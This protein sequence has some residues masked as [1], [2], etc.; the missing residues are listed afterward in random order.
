MYMHQLSCLFMFEAYF[1]KNTTPPPFPVKPVQF[2]VP[3]PLVLRKGFCP[4]GKRKRDCKKC[5]NRHCPCG[6]RRDACVK[7]H[8]SG[9]C[10]HEKRRRQC[11]QCDIVGYLNHQFRSRVQHMMKAK[12]WTKDRPSL[13]F[14]GCTWPEYVVFIEAKM[15]WWNERHTS[16][17]HMTWA[18]TQRDHIKPG[19]KAKTQQEVEALNHYT[20]MQP[21][22]IED[23]L[24]K[25]TKWSLDNEEDWERE[26]FHRRGYGEVY[27]PAN[28]W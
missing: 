15:Q 23:N 3:V 5:G 2:K 7:C 12:N 19:S 1:L 13:S 8:G 25:G 27:L 24:K 18:N 28:F 26:I 6:K 21:L 22:L 14:L 10:Q 4:C 9:I 20:N 16:D 17:Q 11:Q